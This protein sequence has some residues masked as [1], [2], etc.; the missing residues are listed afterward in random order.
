MEWDNLKKYKYFNPYNEYK[1][2][3]M[4]ITECYELVPN[5]YEYENVTIKNCA[6]IGETRLLFKKVNLIVALDLIMCYLGLESI[7]ADKVIECI[8]F[9]DKKIYDKSQLET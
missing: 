4:C 3:D 8:F 9:N 5:T 1:G 6:D 7:L 2:Y